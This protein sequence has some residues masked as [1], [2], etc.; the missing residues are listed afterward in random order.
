MKKIRNFFEALFLI[1]VIIIWPIISLRWA[2]HCWNKNDADWKKFAAFGFI[3]SCAIIDLIITFSLKL[4]S[5]LYHSIPSGIF[6][7]TG[8]ILQVNLI[9]KKMKEEDMRK[10][11]FAFETEK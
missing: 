4:P 10:R 9:M 2:W 6:Y 8:G 1:V 3:G 11:K 5:S 7:V